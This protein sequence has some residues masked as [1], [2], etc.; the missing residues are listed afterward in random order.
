M[1]YA[2]NTHTNCCTLLDDN[3]LLIQTN[4]EFWRGN[5]EAQQ[6]LDRCEFYNRALSNALTINKESREFA[7]DKFILES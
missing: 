4:R 3:K 2:D 5:D 7:K 6:L 1:T